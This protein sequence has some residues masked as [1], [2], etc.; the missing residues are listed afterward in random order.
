MSWPIGRWGT[1]TWALEGRL[2]LFSG[3]TIVVAAVGGTSL[4]YLLNDLW[5]LSL[6]D[7]PTGKD[8]PGLQGPAGNA[9]EQWVWSRKN[10]CVQR[11]DSGS[12]QWKDD[13][14]EGGGAWDDLPKAGSKNPLGEPYV[15]NPEVQRPGPRTGAATWVTQCCLQQETSDVCSVYNFKHK[16]AECDHGV[17]E[18]VFLFGGMGMMESPSRDDDDC[19][20]DHHCASTTDAE[21]AEG[22]A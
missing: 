4:R 10:Q 12:P 3:Q 1:Q 8:F 16:N 6:A 2:F 20:V 19:V 13:L 5:E 9:T 7:N 17:S 15:Y 14:P 22:H 11:G 18:S 21:N